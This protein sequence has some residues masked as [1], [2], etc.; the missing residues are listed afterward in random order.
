MCISVCIAAAEPLP[1]WEMG[2]VPSREICVSGPEE[3]VPAR[4]GILSKRFV[5]TV[6]ASRTGD[7]CGF[8]EEN[9]GSEAAREAL[10]DFLDWALAR[11][12]EIELF[13]DYF[14][15]TTQG[16]DPSSHDWIGPSDIRTWRSRFRP[17]EFLV[18]TRE[19]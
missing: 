13:V 5:Y 6:S 9:D 3:D 7:G 15:P 17:G 12:G 8:Q 1:Y 19:A 14:D 4:K 2:V 11:V 16:I 10:A 18:V